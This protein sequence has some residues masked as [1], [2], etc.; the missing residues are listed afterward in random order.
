M[1][2]ISLREPA[3]LCNKSLVRR[4]AKQVFHVHMENSR[5]KYI[6]STFS[7]RDH[8]KSRVNRCLQLLQAFANLSDHTVQD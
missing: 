5:R 1:M 3:K 4:E 8:E 2:G 7:W 6:S